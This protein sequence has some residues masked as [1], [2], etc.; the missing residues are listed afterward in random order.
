[1]EETRRETAG[2]S[3]KKNR[4][5]SLRREH[6]LLY[7]KRTKNEQ[8]A[9]FTCLFLKIVHS[10]SPQEITNKLV[11]SVKWTTHNAPPQPDGREDRGKPYKLSQRA[12]EAA[13][14]LSGSSAKDL[15][16]RKWLVA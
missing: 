11:F 7:N 4:K 16:G 9:L 1:M 6:S 10:L 14:K 3:I 2:V 15:I 5:I 13:A 12:T 8:L